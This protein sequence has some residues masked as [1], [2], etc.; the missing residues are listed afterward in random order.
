MELFL[1]FFRG[2]ATEFLERTEMSLRTARRVPWREQ[3]G[4][5]HPENSMARAECRVGP[6]AVCFPRPV[7]CDSRS[8]VR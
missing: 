6:E 2:P 3:M 4:E 1:E 7:D 8:L 5:K